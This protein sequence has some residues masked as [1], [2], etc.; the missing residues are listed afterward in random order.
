MQETIINL[1]LIDVIILLGYFGLVFAVAF[2]IG[3]KKKN[4]SS[5]D[6]FL[7]GR[8]LPWY[9]VGGSLFASNIGSEHLIGLAGSGAKSGVAV[10]QFE[11]LACLIL[12]LLGWFFVPFYLRTGVFT[13]PEFLEKRFS[14]QARYY[15]TFISIVGY[16]L[17]KISVSSMCP[18]LL[19]AMQMIPG[20]TKIKSGRILRKPAKMLPRRASLIPRA[21]NVRCTTY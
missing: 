3:D 14:P 11:V 17:T 18:C 19:S 10:A 21:D 4:Q 7:A 2:L 16:I 20:T 12:L 1:E 5:A 8:N 6:Y 15:L 9:L 13:M